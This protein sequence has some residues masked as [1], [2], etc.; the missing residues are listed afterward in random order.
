[1]KEDEVKM[2]KLIISRTRHKT[3][4]NRVKKHQ[5]SFEKRHLYFIEAIEIRSI[6]LLE[7]KIDQFL[8]ATH[9]NHEH[10]ASTLTL[11]YLIE[12]AY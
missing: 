12:R 9:E 10:F 7:K 3:L 5:L 6:C 4:K 2:K 8:K 11:D 1:M